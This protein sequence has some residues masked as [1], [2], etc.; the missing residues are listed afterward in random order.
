MEI[1]IG[2]SWELFFC[3][4]RDT[5]MTFKKIHL[6]L[7]DAIHVYIVYS[8]W[9]IFLITWCYAEKLN[10]FVS[11]GATGALELKMDDKYF[12]FQK[13]IIYIVHQYFLVEKKTSKML[14]KKCIKHLVEI[15]R[16]WMHTTQTRTD[17]NFCT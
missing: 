5:T 16:T 15:Y 17:Q 1:K 13:L 7:S 10:K 3:S 2:A 11:V 12:C 14:S 9:R 8:F 4:F 6:T